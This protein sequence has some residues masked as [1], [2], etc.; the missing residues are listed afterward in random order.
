MTYRPQFDYPSPPPGYEDEDFEYV[1]NDA[2]TP[3]LGVLLASG[4]TSLSIPLLMQNDAPEYLI[5]AIQVGNPQALLG[6][7]FRDGFL[8]PISDPDQFVSSWAFASSQ[9]NN[10]A[11]TEPELQ[12]PGG[13]AILID[14]ANLG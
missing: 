3:A 9:G 2:N 5:R 13:A 4:Q 14:I 7:R 6:I 10:G 11:V 1:F 8:N 12:C